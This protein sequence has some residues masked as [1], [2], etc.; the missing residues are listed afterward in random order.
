MTGWYEASWY[1]LIFSVI[2][3]VNDSF[4]NSWWNK[5]V[6]NS[7]MLVGPWCPIY[8]FGTLIVCYLASPFVA[9]PALLFVAT[10]V[11]CTVL[12]LVAGVLLM[13][14]FARRWWDYSRWP[15][16]IAGYIALPAS[17]WW[18]FLG[19]ALVYLMMPLVQTLVAWLPVMAGKVTLGVLGVL[20]VV[21]MVTT[22]VSLFKLRSTWR[23]IVKLGG[24]EVSKLGL[25]VAEA[26]A[27]W[28]QQRFLRGFPTLKKYFEESVKKA[29]AR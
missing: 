24:S 29:R 26:K 20:F 7:G 27:S 21:D 15:F 5:K 6:I 14:F 23:K 10:A 1:F 22:L 19:L 13:R 28:N 3:W 17:L 8:G 18:G 25:L 4:F 2:G 16:N 12:E 11:L 9:N